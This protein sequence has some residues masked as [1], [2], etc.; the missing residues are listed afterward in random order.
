MQTVVLIALI[1]SLVAL[2]SA[3][4][5]EKSKEW[6]EEN[7]KKDGVVVLPSGLQYKILKSGD[8]TEHPTANTP[9]DCHYRGTLIDGSEFDSSYSRG[10]PSTFAGN[11]VI[12]GW[13]EAMMM[14]VEGDKWELYVPSELAYG[15]NGSPPKI[16]GGDA[17]IFEIEMIKIKWECEPLS[18]DLKGCDDKEAAYVRK[19]KAEYGSD[20]D[21]LEEAMDE[22]RELMPRVSDKATKDLIQSKLKIL[23]KLAAGPRMASYASDEDEF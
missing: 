14:M 15:D 23:D 22:L 8:G 13:T 19:A 7:A 2:A 21:Y 18:A 12:P 17:L 1:L 6:L 5:N 3:G 16:E 10:E 20:L 9:C 4:S 11:Q